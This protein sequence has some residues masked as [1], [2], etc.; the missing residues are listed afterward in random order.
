MQIGMQTNTQ[1]LNIYTKINQGFIIIQ[2]I[3][4]YLA[5]KSFLHSQINDTFFPSKLPA[6]IPT[7][8]YLVA[9]SPILKIFLLNY[10]NIT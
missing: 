7:L 1:S 10:Y 5:E 2:I 6:P 8:C 3:Y 4:C 9:M